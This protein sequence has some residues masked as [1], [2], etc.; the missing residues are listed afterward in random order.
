M[1][2]KQI[3]LKNESRKQGESHAKCQ[4]LRGRRMLKIER[5]KFSQYVKNKCSM[6]HGHLLGTG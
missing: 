5:K 4:K 1:K 3:L 2:G 6:L